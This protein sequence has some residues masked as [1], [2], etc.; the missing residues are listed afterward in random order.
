M[1]FLDLLTDETITEVSEEV[2]AVPPKKEAIVL[3]EEKKPEE[4]LRRADLKIKL[5]TPTSFGTQIEFAKQY[6]KEDIEKVLKDFNIKIKN[7]S[8]FII[9]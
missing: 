8:V 9:T 1:R 5:V 2:L 6:S 3:V 4:L 7:K